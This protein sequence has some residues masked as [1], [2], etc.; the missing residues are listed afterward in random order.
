MSCNSDSK[1][2][3]KE[4]DPM[5]DSNSSV[6]YMILAICF[7]VFNS[8]WAGTETSRM[9]WREKMTPVVLS[10]NR[11]VWGRRTNNLPRNCVHLAFSILSCRSSD[12]TVASDYMKKRTYRYP[13]TFLSL[14]ITA[15]SVEVVKSHLHH[16][17]MLQRWSRKNIRWKHLPWPKTALI[18]V[19]PILV[20]KLALTLIEFPDNIN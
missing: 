8:R 3:T 20:I 10:K 15:K 13:W 11:H 16:F 1:E 9:I 6:T 17:F 18:K 7:Y 4:F 5:N 12:L 2:G 14:Q 19:R